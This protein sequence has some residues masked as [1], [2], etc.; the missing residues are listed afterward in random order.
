MNADTAAAGIAGMGLGG[1]SISACLLAA[2]DT[3]AVV[4]SHRAKR[5]RA[6][7]RALSLLKGL[8]K[9]LI[10]R[11]RVSTSPLSSERRS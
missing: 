10:E 11:L 4:E 9:K 2:G 1:T 6:I 8:K 7:Q 5:R 3:V